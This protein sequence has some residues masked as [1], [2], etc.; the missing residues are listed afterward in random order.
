MSGKRVP[1]PPGT[2]RTSIVDLLSAL[3]SAPV[4]PRKSLNVPVGTISCAQMD[5]VRWAAG[6]GDRVETGALDEDSKDSRRWVC[7]ERTLRT[8][9]GPKTSR[10]S[11]P[12][13]KTMA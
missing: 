7:S 12:G 1:A 9:S 13:Y 5:P 4:S 10:A 2:R 11:K 3:L 6:S 8:S